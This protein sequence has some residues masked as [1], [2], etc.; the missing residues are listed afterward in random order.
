MSSPRWLSLLPL[1]ALAEAP[2]FALQIVE[3][4]DGVTV[5]ATLSAKEPTRIRID[6]APITDVFGNIRSS[7]CKASAAAGGAPP[8]AAPPAVNL[9]GEIALECDHEKG[10]IYVRPVG[11]STKPVNLFVSSAH[12]TY[13]LLLRRAETP[14]D[15]I[16][17]RDPSVRPAAETSVL[18]N[19]P[20]RPPN[21]VRSLKAMLAAM[22]SEHVPPDIRVEDASRPVQLWA[23]VRFT[24]Q[25]VFEG[26]GLVGE[27]YRLTNV[28]EQPIAL[29][30]P[31]FDRDGVVAVS[32]ETHNLRPGDST[33]VHVI[34]RGG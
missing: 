24:L 1:L 33:N 8:I 16:V 19:P 25:R 7:G 32:I 17:I 14:A 22:A 5:E 4:R 20:G 10:E 6:G 3:A 21:Y 15:T 2:A 30:E 29:A 27:S 18:A 9:A 23:E 28:S 12:A 34:R 13:T 26:R 11:N 31:E